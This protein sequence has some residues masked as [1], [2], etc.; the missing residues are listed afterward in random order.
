MALGVT[1]LIL[2]EVS[3][4]TELAGGVKIGVPTLKVNTELAT[5]LGIRSGRNARALFV[6]PAF[7]RI[8]SPEEINGSEIVGS[9]LFV[10]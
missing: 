10:V 3:F 1:V 9:R 7:T 5:E 6:D 2:T 4:V 8:S